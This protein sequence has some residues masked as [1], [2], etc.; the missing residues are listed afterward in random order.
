MT[1]ASEHVE[2]SS[3][4]G[5]LFRYL[6]KS[7]NEEK[8]ASLVN[9]ADDSDRNGLARCISCHELGSYKLV[10]DG[11]DHLV[12]PCDCPRVYMHVPCLRMEY[13]WYMRSPNCPTCSKR[14]D[15][16]SS[17]RDERVYGRLHL[18][19]FLTMVGFVFIAYLYV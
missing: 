3:P 4:I 11:P 1:S 10:Q 7:E 2:T 15:V 8:A 18:L 19:S 12:R 5:D 17:M 9:L 16:W 6:A 14:I 13:K